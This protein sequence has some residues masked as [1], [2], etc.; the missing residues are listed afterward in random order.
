MVKVRLQG[1]EYEVRCFLDILQEV[2]FVEISN[3]SDFFKNKGTDRYKRLYTEAYIKRPK[4]V[5]MRR[6][7]ESEKHKRTITGSV[8]NR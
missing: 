4:I 8:R 6:Q 5:P 7:R 3:T 2:K 1:T